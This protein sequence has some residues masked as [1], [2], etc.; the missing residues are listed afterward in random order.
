MWVQELEYPQ[1]KRGLNQKR[2]IFNNNPQGLQ[3]VAM[4]TRREPFND[5]RVRK[6]LRHLFNRELMIQ[7]LAFNEYIPMD[8]MY[9]GQRLR[10]SRQRERSSTTRRKP[11]QLLAEAGWKDRD[12]CGTSR[13][14]R[15][16]DHPRDRLRGSGIRAL[17]H[18]LPGGPAQGRH[19]AESSARHVGDADQAA[20]RA[21]LRHGRCSPIPASTF[22]EPGSE[23]RIPRWRTRRTPTTSRASRT[24]APTRSWRP[25]RRSSIWRSG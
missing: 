6:A 18:D 21:S 17:L 5:I 24:S 11:L 9:P 23:S 1:I 13:Q 25:T 8:S 12:S 2:K 4:N 7:K 22:P 14:E 16:A 10:E 20:R 15:Q 19:H 3:G